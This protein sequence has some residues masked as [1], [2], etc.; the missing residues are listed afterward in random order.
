MVVDT[1]C[2]LDV[3]MRLIAVPYLDSLEAD[4]ILDVSPSRANTSLAK[5]CASGFVGRACLSCA[6]GFVAV[7]PLKCQQCP[8]TLQTVA[9]LVA[10]TALKVGLSMHSARSS[11]LEK[12]K[13]IHLTDAGNLAAV[14]KIVMAHAAVL[15]LVRDAP[16]AWSAMDS[17]TNSGS[18]V[19]SITDFTL[20]CSFNIGFYTGFR[21]NAACLPALCIIAM[22]I[23]TCVW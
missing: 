4:R 12:E 16:W 11:G 17:I 14:I 21:L 9:L 19:A 3:D 7:E 2:W 8:N 6:S 22:I 10:V 13:V 20:L 1:G 15:E 18:K 5:Q 23:A